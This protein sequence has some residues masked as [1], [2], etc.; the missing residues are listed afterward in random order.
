MLS[1]LFHL[2][3][4]PYQQIA[5]VVPFIHS[6]FCC[7]MLRKKKAYRNPH[8]MWINFHPLLFKNIYF[9]PLFILFLAI[10]S[11]LYWLESLLHTYTPF[12][13]QS[14]VD[15]SQGEIFKNM[16]NVA[17]EHQQMRK[18]RV[19]S[20]Q[21]RT[22]YSHCNFIFSLFCCTVHICRIYNP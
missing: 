5:T 10:L 19:L 4:F 21:K 6:P 8:L 17:G 15:Y 20:F 16:A 12:S 2:Y 18:I 22:C 7:C 1:R 11:L 3:G 14:C 13:L 9:V